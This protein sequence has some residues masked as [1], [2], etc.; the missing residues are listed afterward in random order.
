M[1]LH[2]KHYLF[3]KELKLKNIIK[4]FKVG[5]II[6]FLAMFQLLV[7]SLEFSWQLKNWTQIQ[8]FLPLIPTLWVFLANHFW[9]A[10]VYNMQFWSKNSH[11]FSTLGLYLMSSTNLC[12]LTSSVLIYFYCCLVFIN[13]FSCRSREFYSSWVLTCL[14][15]SARCPYTWRITSLGVKKS[16]PSLCC[17]EFV[18]FSVSGS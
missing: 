17:S 6:F 12:S 14:R 11:S 9:V 2:N 10:Y 5:L 4:C 18:I 8:F 15:I 7:V 13:S 1:N 3:L 16:R